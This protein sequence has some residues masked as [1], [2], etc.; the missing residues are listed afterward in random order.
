MSNCCFVLTKAKNVPRF[1]MPYIGVDRGAYILA[2]LKIPMD[3]A[4]GDF[5]SVT[6]SEKELI[7]TYA[8][9]M[10]ALNP[11]KDDTD[12]EAALKAIDLD[13]YDLIYVY[14]GLGGRLDHTFMNLRIVSMYPNKL[15]MLDDLNRVIAYKKGVY[16]LSKDDYR[17]VSLFTTN[18]ACITI[19]G[20][21]YPLV[22]Q[23]LTITDLYTIS[24]EILQEYA[25]LTVHDG[26]VVVMQCND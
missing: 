23:D 24:N 8:K 13:A 22:K 1:D 20:V 6:L 17:Y 9:E 26:I 5:D 19:E 25:T 12:F 4:I 16:K 21:K 14:G 11:V 3:L 18:T 15:C 10:I 7:Q 2:S